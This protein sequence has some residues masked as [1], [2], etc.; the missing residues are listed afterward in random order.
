MQR[1]I[2]GIIGAIA[3]GVLGYFATGWMARQGFY[4][5]LLPGV[6]TGVG[7]LL[8]VFKNKLFMPV[9]I[10]ICATLLIYFTEWKYFPFSR[11][12]S[13]SYFIEHIGDLRPLT[14][15]MA[16]GGGLI[17]FSFPFNRSRRINAQ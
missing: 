11:D 4:S 5:V 17:A 6:L 16:I 10:G 1:S 7:S 12:N 2:H 14:H 9:V 15:L 3:G 8:G 13:F